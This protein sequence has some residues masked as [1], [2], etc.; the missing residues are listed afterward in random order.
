MASRSGLI[1]LLTDYQPA[2]P[3]ERAYRLRMLDLAAVAHDPFDRNHWSPGHFTA[4][5]FV[6]HP[7]GTQVLLVHHAK[8]GRWLQPGGHVDPDDPSP[9]HAARREVREET[10]MG[11]LTSVSEAVVDL[12]VHHFPARSGQPEHEH[13]DLRFAFVAGDDHIEPG[14]GVLSVRWVG[15]A[16]LVD[17]EADASLRRPIGKLLFE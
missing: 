9:L 3:V 2:D 8:I 10:G 16:D 7:D 11:E 6:I 4:S 12:D 5:A 1:R 15:L 13:H 17:V 14:G